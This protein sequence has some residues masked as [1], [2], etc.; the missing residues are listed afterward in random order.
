MTCQRCGKNRLR[1]SYSC[2]DCGEICC[3]ECFMTNMR[4]DL[5]VE[6]RN[7]VA[8]REQER[9]E[10]WEEADYTGDAP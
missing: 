4:C 10:E 2:I 1:G 3:E 9:E 6:R 7:D 8:D 5:C